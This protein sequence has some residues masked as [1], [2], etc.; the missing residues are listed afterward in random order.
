MPLDRISFILQNKL[1]NE[2]RITFIKI[3]EI[4][5]KGYVQKRKLSFI[6]KQIQKIEKTAKNETELFLLLKELFL[7]S[8]NDNDLKINE[9]KKED[10]LKE[11]ILSENFI[12]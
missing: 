9:G 4:I 10:I 11:I 6:Y 3:S 12:G 8:F 1:I 7:N 5:E 2:E